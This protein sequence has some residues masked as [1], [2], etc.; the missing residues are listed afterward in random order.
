MGFYLWT[1]A[2]RGN[3]V[4]GF[5]F[6]INS[7]QMKTTSLHSFRSDFNFEIFIHV[8]RIIPIH[9]KRYARFCRP[10][11]QPIPHCGTT[12]G[13]FAWFQKYLNRSAPPTYVTFSLICKFYSSACNNYFGVPNYFKKLSGVS[14][15]WSRRKDFFRPFKVGD[16]AHIL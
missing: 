15:D 14:C 11:V 12:F 4:I 3:N 1:H 5:K 8:P 2:M 9:W 10:R 6:W 16:I 13:I 7:I